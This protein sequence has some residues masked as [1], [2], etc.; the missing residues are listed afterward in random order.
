M[1]RLRIALLTHSTNPRGGVV[2]ALEFAEALT[3]L[4]HEAVVHAPDP[5]G[6]GFFRPARCGVMSVEAAPFSGDTTQMVETRIADYVRHFE[7]PGNRR[8]DVFHAQ[9]GISGNALATLK[10]RGLVARFARTVHHIDDFSCARLSALQHR[11]IVEADAHFTVSRMWQAELGKRYALSPIVVGNGVDV[12]RFS[13]QRDGSEAPLRTRLG[14]GPG[15]VIL[16]V[17][18]IEA[19]KNTLRLLEAFAQLHAVSPQAQLVIAG[20]ATVLDHGSYRAEFSARLTELGL[21]GH[22]VIETGPLAQDDMP[23]LYRLA[24]LLAF[25]SIKEGFGL[26]VLEAMASGVPVMV[27]HIAPFT[28][29]LSDDDVVW[30]D[31]FHAGSIANAM[32][33]ALTPALA[34]RLKHRG[35]LK[36][37]RHDWADTARA[38]VATYARLR[39]NAHA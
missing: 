22:A 5:K 16:S 6:A 28:E 27:S 14:L 10:N 20:G 15:P 32:A 11:A 1:N 13:P 23:T 37:S 8:F 31:P 39:E 21:P 26:V 33:T 25:P 12:A 30:C 35:P 7:R 3:D 34:A 38:H 18:G 36:A 29:H 17:G 24:D 4:G 19:R 9:D 2:H